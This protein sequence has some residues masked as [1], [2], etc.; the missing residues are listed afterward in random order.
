ML[1]NALHIYL[2]RSVDPYYL[3]LFAVSIAMLLAGLVLATAGVSLPVCLLI[4]TLAPAATVVGYETLGRARAE[5]SLEET[6]V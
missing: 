5:V 6:L 2:L 4:V 1:S 3:S